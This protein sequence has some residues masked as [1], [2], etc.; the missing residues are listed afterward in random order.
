[1]KKI[2]KQGKAKRLYS[3]VIFRSYQCHAPSFRPVTPFSVC[4][5]ASQKESLFGDEM[6]WE[7]TLL[8]RLACAQQVQVLVRQGEELI[9]QQLALIGWGG[10]C[11]DRSQEC[12]GLVL[13]IEGQLVSLGG[14]VASLDDLVGYLGSWLWSVGLR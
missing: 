7:I 13:C 8:D 14:L 12:L 10:Y 9:A 11:D 2:S 3:R 6:E 1:M 5:A 4:F